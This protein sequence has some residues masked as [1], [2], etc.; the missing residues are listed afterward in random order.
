MPVKVSRSHLKCPHAVEAA[1]RKACASG[2]LEII[3]NPRGEAVL[4]SI[5]AA[6]YLLTNRTS[7]IDFERTTVLRK[8]KPI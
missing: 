8:L 3:F 4:R 1:L 2:I 6:K 5:C 7:I